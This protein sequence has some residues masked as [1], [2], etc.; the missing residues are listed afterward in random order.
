MFLYPDRERWV[1]NISRRNNWINIINYSFFFNWHRFFDFFFNRWVIFKPLLFREINMSRKRFTEG[2][3]YLRVKSI[4][5]AKLLKSIGVHK[6]F[7]TI[8]LKLNT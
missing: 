7:N 2:S 6:R 8:K 4:F 5:S 1:L 3:Y